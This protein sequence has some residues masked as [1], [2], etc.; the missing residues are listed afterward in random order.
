MKITGNSAPQAPSAT[1]GTAGSGR[2]TAA[3]RQGAT[4]Q[5]S[6]SGGASTGAT[7]S[8]LSQL[9]SQFSQA[10]FNAS[11]VSEITAAIANG[12]YKV[13]AGAVADG[14]LSSTAAMAGKSGRSA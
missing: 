9:E 8:R 5:A 3:A 12:S 10:D 1:S 13:N 6:T 2:G 7:T 14:L 11:K 4:S